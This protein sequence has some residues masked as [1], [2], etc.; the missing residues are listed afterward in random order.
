MLKEA[1]NHFI[2]AKRKD[3]KLDKTLKKKGYR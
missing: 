2:Q 1:I 3:K